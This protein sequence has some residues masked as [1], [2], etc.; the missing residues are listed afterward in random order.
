MYP[1]HRELVDGFFKTDEYN[2][3]TKRNVLIHM[4]GFSNFWVFVILDFYW[5]LIIW[6][7]EYIMSKVRLELQF[8]EE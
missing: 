3:Y 7:F 6:R 1:K 8:T 4:G 2:W 5:L